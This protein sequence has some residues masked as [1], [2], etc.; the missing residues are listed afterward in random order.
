MIRVFDKS[1]RIS[2][3]QS[4]CF[5]ANRR[6]SSGLAGVFSRL[7]KK[8]QGQDTTPPTPPPPPKQ[9]SKSTHFS[10]TFNHHQLRDYLHEH[11]EL[12]PD[13]IQTLFEEE[14]DADIL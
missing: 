6:Y 1:L 10:P 2:V 4:K 3:R 12:S 5:Y 7:A 13:V 9:T 14:I 8:W 11:S